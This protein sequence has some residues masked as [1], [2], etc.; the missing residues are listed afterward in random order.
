MV[1]MFMKR[2]TPVAMNSPTTACLKA[3]FLISSLQGLNETMT[4]NTRG[5]GEVSDGC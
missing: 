1:E 5:G 4:S 3:G 2:K